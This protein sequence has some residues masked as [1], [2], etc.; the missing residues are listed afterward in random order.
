M[1]SD[2]GV[3]LA[4]IAL[5]AKVQVVLYLVD[6]YCYGLISRTQLVN[7]LLDILNHD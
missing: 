5:D 1:D 7:C 3:D 4:P 2:S 6:A